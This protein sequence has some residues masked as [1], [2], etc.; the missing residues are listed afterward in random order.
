VP[1][2]GSISWNSEREERTVADDVETAEP[3]PYEAPAIVVLGEVDE[4][5]HTVQPSVSF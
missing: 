2:P 3:E 5:T 1:P 4:L